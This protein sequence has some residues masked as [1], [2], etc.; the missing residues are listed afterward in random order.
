[1]NAEEK[2]QEQR[3]AFH[4]WLA[5]LDWQ[6]VLQLSRDISIRLDYEAARMEQAQDRD[7]FINL[8]KRHW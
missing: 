3:K 7:S 4:L 1:M 5:E 6:Q 2:F 8:M